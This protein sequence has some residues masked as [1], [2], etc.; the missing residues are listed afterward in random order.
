MP[1]CIRLDRRKLIRAIASVRAELIGPVHAARG[2]RMSHS[3]LRTIRLYFSIS[4]STLIVGGKRDPE[5]PG[6]GRRVDGKLLYGDGQ[7]I[8]LGA[9]YVLDQLKTSKAP[10]VEMWISSCG[11]TWD[12]ISKLEK[13]E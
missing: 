6:F 12:F 5:C 11:A 3:A 9:K 8:Q 7:C 1:S 4:G 10:E 13:T 2:N